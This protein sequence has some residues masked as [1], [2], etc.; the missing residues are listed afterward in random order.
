M[1]RY[2]TFFVLQLK[3]CFGFGRFIGYFCLSAVL[4]AK[5]FVNKSEHMLHVFE[6]LLI[7]FLNFCTVSVNMLYG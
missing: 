5:H 6:H 7:G 3:N 1:A 4:S 2:M